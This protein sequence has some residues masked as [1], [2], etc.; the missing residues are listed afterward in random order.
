MGQAV[1]SRIESAGTLTLAGV[2]DKGDNAASVF[3]ASD[4]V[5]DFT[6]P[7]ATLTHARLASEHG[8]ALVVGTTGLTAADHTALDEAA[9]TVA[10]VQAGNFSLGVTLLANLVEKAAAAL[11]DVYDI[12]I[13]ETHHRYKLDAPS[14][15]AVLLGEAAAK[16][17]GVALSDVAVRGRD[18][19]T[20]E[21]KR[22]DIGFAALRGG[23]VVGDHSVLFAGDSEVLTLSH[24]AQDRGLFADGA[25]V[26]ARFAANA[27]P[28]RYSMTE[29][30]GL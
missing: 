24:H 19:I 23:A 2:A 10:I 20:G 27:G 16:G 29:V 8:T 30:L 5:I 4:V 28:G 3:Q 18:G 14:G 6:P 11:S 22:G 13:T 12:E 25:L 21:R 1:K 15:T 26:A 9:R 17:R 7:G